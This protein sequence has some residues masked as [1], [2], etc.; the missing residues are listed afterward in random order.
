MNL[1][2]FR[3]DAFIFTA[4]VILFWLW[5][6]A[7]WELKGL[8]LQ[9][10]DYRHTYFF[11]GSG[12]GKDAFASPYAFV[13]SAFLALVITFPVSY[14][15]KNRKWLFWVGLLFGLVSWSLITL[16]Y[17]GADF[18]LYFLGRPILPTL[19]VFSFVGY[20]AGGRLQKQRQAQQKSGS[21]SNFL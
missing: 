15:C 8:I 4:G 21:E 20:W 9:I 19:L 16:P 5:G 11:D 12:E 3:N 7:P 1:L 2:S 13:C 10:I 18:L 17:F 14:Y 6:W